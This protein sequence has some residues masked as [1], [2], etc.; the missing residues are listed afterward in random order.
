M[1]MANG[2]LGVEREA[3]HV[4]VVEVVVGTHA[5]ATH[6]LVVVL[7]PREARVAVVLVLVQLEK[8]RVEGSDLVVDPC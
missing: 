7:G 1:A 3:E 4:S 8:E 5:E 6:A 2:R